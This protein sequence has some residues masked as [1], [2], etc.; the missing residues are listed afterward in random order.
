[1]SA[2][3]Y[4]GVERRLAAAARPTCMRASCAVSRTQPFTMMPLHLQSG[5]QELG[6]VEA[7]QS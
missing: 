3:Q 4:T 6:A 1:M 2:Q 7:L 5:S